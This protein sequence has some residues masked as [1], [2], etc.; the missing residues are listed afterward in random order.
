MLN[1]RGR[2]EKGDQK[3]ELETDFDFSLTKEVRVHGSAE[4]AETGRRGSHRNGKPKPEPTK[5]G[6]GRAG[7]TETG[8]WADVV[9]G[10][11]IKDKSEGVDS[12]ESRNESDVPDS[13]EMFDLEEPNLRWAKQT[14]RQPKPTPR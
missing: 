11:G 3:A 10:L 13:I 4:K 9:K 14:K 6:E 5:N 1:L 2:N 7:K 12:I 8:T